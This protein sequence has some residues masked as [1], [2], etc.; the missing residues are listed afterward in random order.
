[1]RTFTV[2]VSCAA[3]L[4]LVVDSPYPET[5]REVVLPGAMAVMLSRLA[6]RNSLF[7]RATWIANAALKI[8]R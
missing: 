5:R 8:D 1:M 7:P 2:S 6:I 4:S 3:D